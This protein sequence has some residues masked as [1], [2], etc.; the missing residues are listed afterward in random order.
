MK[1]CTNV[2]GHGCASSV[3]QLSTA[4]LSIRRPFLI[5]L[6][7]ALAAALVQITLGGVVRV[8]GSGLGCPDWP[9]CHGNLLPPLESAALLE[10]SHRLT[11]VAVGVL[12]VTASIMAW[13]SRYRNRRS[14][15]P[16]S[17]ALALVVTAAVLGAV[18]VQ[19]ELAWWVRLLHLGIAEA[20]A[21][22]LAAAI[23]LAVANP[24]GASAPARIVWRH[25]HIIT[26]LAA[27][28]LVILLGS[29][30][31]GIGYGS[32]CATWPLCRGTLF[33]EGSQYA[34]H[35]SHRYTAVVLGVL[36]AAS[37]L[38]AY[39]R[40]GSLPYAWRANLAALLIFVV[41]TLVGAVT[42][43]TGF[44]TPLRASH[45][46]LASLLWVSVAFATALEMTRVGAAPPDG[47]AEDLTAKATL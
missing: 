21:G 38:M 8:T 16:V 20:A 34:I 29:Y 6:W 9:L 45:L 40:R 39:Q 37:T 11:A 19:T 35:M 3:G 46:A 14:V 10:Y 13:R 5:I 42:V 22:C 28:F 36:I 31:T 7:A 25:G 47:P 44:S 24:T 1:L 18:T 17:A 4:H 41:Q 43:W 15:L 23:V 2:S 32:S 26:T 30:V 12:V 33:P 27:S